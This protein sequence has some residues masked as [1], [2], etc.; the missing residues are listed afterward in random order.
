L[1]RCENSVAHAMGYTA[2]ICVLPF[3]VFCDDGS[4]QARYPWLWDVDMDNRTF[5]ALLRGGDAPPPHDQRWAIVRLLEYAPYS[6]IRRLLPDEILLQWWPDVSPRLR[7]KTRRDGMAFVCSW[8]KERRC[9]H[10]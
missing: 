7:S 10:A 4:M 8:L 1:R 9:K 2:T 3:G 6:E 5:E